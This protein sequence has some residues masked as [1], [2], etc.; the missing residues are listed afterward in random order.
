MGVGQVVSLGDRQWRRRETAALALADLL[1]RANVAAMDGPAVEV[2]WGRAI[3]VLDDVKVCPYTPTHSHT[4]THTN[5]DAHPHRGKM[6]HL[7]PILT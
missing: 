4:R 2:L 5:T 3:R 7:C 6:I 1:G